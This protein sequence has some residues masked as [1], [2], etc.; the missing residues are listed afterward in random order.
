MR[1]KC[2]SLASNNLKIS[3]ELTIKHAELPNKK[4][5][6]TKKYGDLTIERSVPT[7]WS[8]K[9]WSTTQDQEGTWTK[10]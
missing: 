7:H 3:G 10:K 6:D 1:K 8:G 4:W 9:D 5:D 2:I